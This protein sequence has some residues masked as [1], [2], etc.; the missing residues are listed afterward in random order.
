MTLVWRTFH[1]TKLS[2][3][4]AVV[5]GGQPDIQLWFP[6]EWHQIWG[7]GP[8]VALAHGQQDTYGT[9]C[10]L[11]G[12]KLP[13]LRSPP[14]SPPPHA[15]SLHAQRFVPALHTCGVL[16]CALQGPG[17]AGRLS[18]YCHVSLSAS[19][20]PRQLSAPWASLSVVLATCLQT[21]HWALGRLTS[22]VSNAVTCVRV[23]VNT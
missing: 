10:D 1:F 9:G 15:G 7:G 4:P 2:A 5:L 17:E 13:L 18:A 21:Q 16:P 6:G 12:E 8:R 23:H 20:I 3:I 14:T 22:S 19:T 11:Q